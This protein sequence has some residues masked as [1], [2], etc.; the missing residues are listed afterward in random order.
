MY[1]YAVSNSAATDYSLWSLI[2]FFF[3]FLI[4]LFKSIWVIDDT[5]RYAKIRYTYLNVYVNIPIYLCEHT[6]MFMWTYI[7]MYMWT[8]LYVYVNIPICLCEPVRFLKYYQCVKL[9][10]PV[11]SIYWLEDGWQIFEQI[12]F[13]FEP[14]YLP[15]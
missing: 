1:S 14:F 15:R 5:Y 13:G 2:H 10:N 9:L 4:W 11:V 12:D 6:Y 3:C 8:H 7:Y